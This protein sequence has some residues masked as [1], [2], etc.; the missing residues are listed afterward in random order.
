MTHSTGLYHG[1]PV[2]NSIS[3]NMDFSAVEGAITCRCRCA[4]LLKGGQWNPSLFVCVFGWVLKGGGGGGSVCADA[5]NLATEVV[6]GANKRTYTCPQLPLAR[7][8]DT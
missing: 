2:R 7:S 6:D 1:V 8:T 5:P 4:T 3:W